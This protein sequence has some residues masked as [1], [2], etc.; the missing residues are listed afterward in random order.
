M[1]FK[2]PLKVHVHIGHVTL[3]LAGI[4]IPPCG[5]W[6]VDLVAYECVWYIL[7]AFGIGILETFDWKGMI[8]RNL[9]TS[10]RFMQMHQILGEWILEDQEKSKHL[11]KLSPICYDSKVSHSGLWKPTLFSRDL[12]F[13]PYGNLQSNTRISWVLLLTWFIS[14]ESKP[15]LHTS[16]YHQ[17]SRAS[18]CISW[19]K[20]I[21]LVWFTKI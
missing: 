14:A 3:P 8:T 1:Y 9:H 18:S 4:T 21:P 12:E 7:K 20:H 2:S 11:M 17:N 19:S 16:A 15:S 5:F 10:D 6:V 13:I